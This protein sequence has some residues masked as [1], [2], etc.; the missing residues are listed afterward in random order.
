MRGGPGSGGRSAEDEAYAYLLEAIRSGRLAGGTHLVAASISSELGTSSIP[1]REAMRRLAS[2]GFVT[3]RSNRGAFVAMLDADAVMELYEMR[4]VLEGLA[5][6]YSATRFDESGSFEGRVLLQRL[7]RARSAPEDFI[8][9]HNQLHDL[10]NSYCPRPRLVAEILRLRTAAEPFLRLTL[11]HSREAYDA[12]V[13]EH[14]ELLEVF[15]RGDPE[16]CEA[17]MRAHILA[18]DVKTLLPAPAS[19]RPAGDGASAA[20]PVRQ[21]QAP[22]R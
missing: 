21:P 1:V 6:R 3:L 7:S 13:G 19:P 12:T 14:T 22:D 16:A 10:I 18:T 4:A 2:E 11:C 8:R 15:A 20:A 5:A 9:A 17:A